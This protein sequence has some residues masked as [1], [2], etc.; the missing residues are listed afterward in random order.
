MELSWSPVVAT[1]GNQWQSVV[2]ENG[3]PSENGCHG[4]QL[5]ATFHGKEGVD[6]SS[7]SEGSQESPAQAGLFC[8]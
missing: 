3:G 1:G 4:L 8:T 2:G 7:P 6:S 5:R